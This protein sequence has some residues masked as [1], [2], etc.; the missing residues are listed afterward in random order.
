[1]EITSAKSTAPSWI[2]KSLPHTSKRTKDVTNCSKGDRGRSPSTVTSNHEHRSRNVKS[3]ETA[4]PQSSRLSQY[5]KFFSDRPEE[6]EKE[7]TKKARIAR[8]MNVLEEQ[9]FSTPSADLRPT[10]RTPPS[11]LSQYLSPDTWYSD[12]L[13]RHQRFTLLDYC[14]SILYSGLSWYSLE[15]RQIP[16]PLTSCF[17]IHRRLETSKAKTFA[18]FIEQSSL[19]ATTKHL[20]L[21][22]REVVFPQSFADF[23]TFDLR[24]D[25]SYCKRLC[26]SPDLKEVRE[27]RKQIN[28]LESNLYTAYSLDEAND[29]YCLSLPNQGDWRT[30]LRNIE[31]KL[32]KHDDLCAPSVADRRVYCGWLESQG[33]ICT[34]QSYHTRPY[35]GKFDWPPSWWTLSEAGV[36]L[37]SPTPEIIW[38]HE[39]R[40]AE[41]SHDLPGQNKRSKRDDKKVLPCHRG[42]MHYKERSSQSGERYSVGRSLGPESMQ[43][44]G[45]TAMTTPWTNDDDIVGA[46]MLSVWKN[47]AG[48]SKSWRRC[49]KAPS[50]KL[51]QNQKMRSNGLKIAHH[52][53]K[54]PLWVPVVFIRFERG[55]HPSKSVRIWRYQET[56]SPKETE[57]IDEITLLNR[58]GETA[59]PEK[60]DAH[61][62]P[63]QRMK[64]I[65]PRRD[66]ISASNP[67]PGKP[68]MRL[69]WKDR[70]LIHGTVQLDR[71]LPSGL[72]FRSGWRIV[73]FCRNDNHADIY[74][75]RAD[76]ARTEGEPCLEAHVF[77][78]EYH[79]NSE[80]YAKRQ[81]SRMRESG[82]CLD[83]FWY[84]GRHIFIMQVPKQMPQFRLKNT[85]DE[86]PSLVHR[87]KCIAYV[88]L[89]RR[90]LRGKPSYAAVAGQTRGRQMM[91]QEP[92][93]M[94]LAKSALEKE[95]E[96]IEKTRVKK[97]E[98]QRCKRQAAREA[99][100]AKADWRALGRNDLE[101]IQRALRE[102][103][104][105]VQKEGVSV[106]A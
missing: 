49:A 20:F 85:E 41:S 78:D 58:S 60:K 53:S 67:E 71:F 36:V 70:T 43:D 7:E 6:K 25:W 72:M 64:L 1:M 21:S 52:F 81:K 51:S 94:P 101:V 62:L 76:G 69:T 44:T 89:Q 79:G 32:R 95:L 18:E 83:S 57:S 75:L 86:F 3:E 90:V 34:E 30:L 37:L 74:F 77:L 24:D 2:R 16:I 33:F 84:E 23:R 66:G 4:P 91:L 88:A 92:R 42:H 5:F 106:Q 8:K 26:R 31:S 63:V 47:T 65:D 68:F 29:Q 35:Y 45:T 80:T 40:P 96:Q 17:G 61:D 22:S 39:D 104:V 28:T 15:F 59:S 48:R 13:R 73:D 19:G 27:L 103:I 100:R 98:K 55:R 14:D 105:E 50:S 9:R 12:Y 82:N 99:N 11:L 56:R 54:A 93:S 10:P 97:K 38:P 87:R 102:H 46:N